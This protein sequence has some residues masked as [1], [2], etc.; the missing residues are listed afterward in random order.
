MT[1]RCAPASRPQSLFMVEV[2][3]G[4]LGRTFLETDRDDN[5]RVEIVR[6]IR[7]GSVNV[8]KVLEIDEQSGTCT[9]VTEDILAEA[10]EAREPPSLQDSFNRLEQLRDHNRKLRVEAS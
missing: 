7:N 2:D 9:D 6:Q 3:Y 8:I 5:S 1:C 10:A 4:R